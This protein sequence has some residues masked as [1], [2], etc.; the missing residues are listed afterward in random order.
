MD[1]QA[2]IIERV[3]KLLALGG[4]NPNENERAIAMER[5]HRLIAKY[6]LDLASLTAE[7]KAKQ[8]PY[9]R[10]AYINPPMKGN[11]AARTIAQS[12][13][14][15]YFCK[16]FYHSAGTNKG[17]WLSFVG[18]KTNVAI[19]ISITQSA[20][21]ALQSEGRE[22]GSKIRG[23]MTNFMNAASLRVF[24]RCNQL[25]KE[26][27]AGTLKEEGTT[28]NLPALRNTYLAELNGAD[29]FI[30]QGLGINLHIKKSGMRGGSSSRGHEEGRLAG[31]RVN[32]RPSNAPP[33]SRKAIQ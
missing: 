30:K 16:M 14:K 15:L 17:D 28:K 32:L 6:N 1:E 23:F 29:D 13:A 22:H 20:I 19:A 2:K 24:A 11:A 18:R 8:E 5:A 31:D 4:N 26:A 12:V 33:S 10:E 3:K 9:V 27:E 25:I 7:E 21:Y